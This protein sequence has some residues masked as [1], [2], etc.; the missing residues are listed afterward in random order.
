MWRVSITGTSC[1]VNP[2]IKSTTFGE[3]RIPTKY[4]DLEFEDG[5]QLLIYAESINMS[6]QRSGSIS[7]NGVLKDETEGLVDTAM[8]SFYINSNL[9]INLS[10]VVN[11]GRPVTCDINIIDS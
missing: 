3:Y 7:Y 11:N 6:V 1:V 5:E 10:S 9:E 4:T 2:I 8:Y